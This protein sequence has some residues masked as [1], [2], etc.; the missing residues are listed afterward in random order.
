MK[1]VMSLGNPI[2]SDDNIGNIILDK[3]DDK[4][5]VFIYPI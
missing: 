1:A 3:L 4:I 2:K 5:I